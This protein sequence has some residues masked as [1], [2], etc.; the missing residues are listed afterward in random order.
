VVLIS[1]GGG[2]NAEQMIR[3]CGLNEKAD[4]AGFIAVYPK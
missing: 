2:S 3:F 4:Q 1:H